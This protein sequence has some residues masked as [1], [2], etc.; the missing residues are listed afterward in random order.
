MEPTQAVLEVNQ[1]F[2]RAFEALSL[3]MMGE[4]WAC[5]ESDVCIHPGWEILRGW[6]EIRESWRVIFANTGFMRFEASE[7]SVE[8]IGAVACLSCV[9]NIFSVVGDMTIHSRVACTNLFH[10]TEDGW[11][12][13]LHHGSPIASTQVVQQHDDEIA[14]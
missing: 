2:Y 14:N 11:R 1:Q 6:E 5:R 13:V 10:L 12:M 7:L 8:I 4:V 3:E 9:E